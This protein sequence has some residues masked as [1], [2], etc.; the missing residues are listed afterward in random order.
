MKI[1]LIILIFLAVFFFLSGCGSR[2]APKLKVAMVTDAGGLNDYSF[3]D[4]AH[5][6]MIRIME[7][8]GCD[9]KVVESKKEEDYGK[10]LASLAEEKYDLIFAIGSLLTESVKKVAPVY[11][12]VHFA[13]IDG[14]ISD[15]HNVT[16]VLFRE[17]EG[18][19]LAGVLAG[20][21]TRTKKVGF[22]GG[23]KI[24]VVEKFETGYRAGVIT[25]NP[26]IQILTDYTDSFSDVEKGRQIALSQLERGADIIFHAS[27]GCGEGVI[28]AVTGKGFPNYVIGVDSDQDSISPNHVLT[29]VIKSLDTAVFDTT[30][31][32]MDGRFK[33]GCMFLGIKEGGISLSPMK[34]TK[35]IIGPD[36][37]KKIDVMKDLIIKGEI[38]VPSTLK[39]LENFKPPVKF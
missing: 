26:E 18:A 4:S 6:G 39:D 15:I 5:R 16:C 35:D 22:I 3:N 36:I 38:S 34:Y 11:P 28:E 32:F 33:Y 19:F 20:L 21:M 25:A 8:L 2:Q 7:E 29:S 17:E 13:I 9:I 37:L 10:N 1:K 27:G 30:K 23:M 12:K 14:N 24:P 31:D